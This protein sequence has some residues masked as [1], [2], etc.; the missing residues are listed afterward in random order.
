MDQTRVKLNVYGLTNSQ[1]Q[2]GAYALI[3]SEEGRR[4]LPVIVG[5]AEAQSIAIALE[6][7][8]PVRPLTHDLFIA[9]MKSFHI[10][11]REVFIYKFEDGVYFSEMVFSDETQDIRIDSRTSDAVA[12][13]LRLKCEIYTSEQIMHKCGVIPEDYAAIDKSNSLSSIDF[14]T[15]KDDNDQL[16]D[17][18]ALLLND[19]LEERME[20]AISEENYESAKMFKEELLRREKE[21]DDTL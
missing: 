7:I 21:G 18:L 13:A 4:W 10:R 8:Q 5:V 19:E 17:W 3:L 16:K 1:M 9:F 2:S 12:I 11:L 6:E 20:N 15:K 14:D